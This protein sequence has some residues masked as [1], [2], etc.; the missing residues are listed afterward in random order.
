MC[1]KSKTR[2]LMVEDTLSVARMTEAFLSRPV[3]TSSMYR[4]PPPPWTS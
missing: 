3:T 4:R 1:G 2:V